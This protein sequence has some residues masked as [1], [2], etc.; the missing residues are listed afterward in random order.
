V[1]PLL[2]EKR[3]GLTGQLLAFI[4]ISLAAAKNLFSLYECELLRAQIMLR[5]LCLSLISTPELTKL[6]FT[7]LELQ[8]QPLF[9]RLL[10]GQ[11]AA[12]AM[13]LCRGKLPLRLLALQLTGQALHLPVT[14]SHQGL[15]SHVRSLLLV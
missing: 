2:L 7:S 5:H 1:A 8:L 6:G 10:I 13:H 9:V 14:L 11:L 4:K 12:E 3:L 15:C